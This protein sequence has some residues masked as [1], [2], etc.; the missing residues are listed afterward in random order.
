MDPVVRQTGSHAEYEPEWESAFNF[1]IK[2]TPVTSLI[3]QWCSTDAQ[4][5][6]RTY[7]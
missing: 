2:L 7:R 5:C 6:I 3:Q 1:H 4:I